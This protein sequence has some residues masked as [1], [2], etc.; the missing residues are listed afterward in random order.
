[1]GSIPRQTSLDLSINFDGHSVRMAG[2]PERP[3]WV[4]RDVCRVLHVHHTANALY[5]AGVT[6]EERGSF[7][8]H[9]LGGPQDVT[10]VTEPG[11]WKLVLI[12][13]KPAAV[14]FKH[15][16]ASDVLPCIRE[17][18]C[19]P[20]P[21][22]PALPP[23]APPTPLALARHMLDALEAHDQKIAEVAARVGRIEARA[24]VAEIE[25]RLLPP[26]QVPAPAKTARAALNERVQAWGA[27]NG[28]AFREAWRKLKRELYHRCSFDAEARAHNSGRHWLDEVEDAGLMPTLYAIACEV[29]EE[30]RAA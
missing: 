7:R 21:T 20:A 4:A 6:A 11:L 16:L 25:L 19:Y 24:E 2:T 23:P 26:A 13:R 14:R 27:A 30:T 3:E 15:W 18:G 28:G 22:R 8:V 9:T 12:S 10:T 29:L 1:M 5:N 17:H